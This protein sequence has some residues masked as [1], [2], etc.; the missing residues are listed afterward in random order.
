M[1]GDF[2]LILLYLFLVIV[3]IGLF[4]VL[5]GG[6]LVVGIVGGIGVGVFYGFKNYF[7]SLAEEIRLR[8]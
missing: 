3:F 5:I 2:F 1:I 7:S 6:S 4:L 8:K